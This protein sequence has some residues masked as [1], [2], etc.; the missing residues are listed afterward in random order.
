MNQD[1]EERERDEDM[2]DDENQP[3]KYTV[4]GSADCPVLATDEE[5]EFSMSFRIP[6]IENLE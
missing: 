5:V 1:A 4:L 6:K 2:R 3:I